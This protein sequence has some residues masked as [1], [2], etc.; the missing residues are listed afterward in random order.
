ML[1]GDL[2][3]GN[4]CAAR[5]IQGKPAVWFLSRALIFSPLQPEALGPYASRQLV[6][7][8]RSQGHKLLRCVLQEV[9]PAAGGPRRKAKVEV[10]SCM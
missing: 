2:E 8:L 9:S 7:K 6:R 4:G 10:G 5:R 3:S 1:Q